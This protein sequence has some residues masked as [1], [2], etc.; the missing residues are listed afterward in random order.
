[1]RAMGLRSGVN[2]L[3]WFIS[4]YVAMLIVAFIVSFILKFGY[5]FPETHFTLIFLTL[6]TFAFSAIMLRF[7]FS[8]KIKKK[9]REKNFNNFSCLVFSSL[10]FYFI[11]LIWF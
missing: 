1:M 7:Q 9:K 11:F 4:T 5:I 8:L 6:A 3:A 10:L 2:W